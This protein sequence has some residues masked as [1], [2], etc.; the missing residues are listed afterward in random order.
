MT[1]TEF[2]E[3]RIAEDEKAARRA[4]GK[5]QYDGNYGDTAAEEVI[6]MGYNEG[7]RRRGMR[8]FERWMPARVLAECEAKRRVVGECVA[9][10]RREDTSGAVVAHGVV[11]ALVVVYADHPDY[12]P[13]WAV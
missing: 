1:I 2:L 6:G 9:A 5:A 13:E 4:L 3:A 12:R 11:A 10:M 8:H 7:C